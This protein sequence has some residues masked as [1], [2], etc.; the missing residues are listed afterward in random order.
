M[1]FIGE[2]VDKSDERGYTCAAG[3]KRHIV[4]IAD[5]EIPIGQLHPD[6]PA[7]LKFILHTGGVASPDGIGDPQIIPLARGTGDGEDTGFGPE[8]AGI[9][10]IE[11]QVKELAGFKAG[12]G[13]LGSKIDGIDMIAVIGDFTYQAT[14]F[15]RGGHLRYTL[16]GHKA[17][18]HGPDM[19]QSLV[20]DSGINADE[21]SVAHDE[22]CVRQVPRNAMGDV[23]I[24]GVTQEIAAEEVSGFDAVGFQKCGQVVAGKIGLIFHSDDIAEPGGIGI[25]RGPGK[26]ETVFEGFQDLGEFPEILLTPGDELVK[27]PE[28]GATDGGLHVRDLEVVADM[29]VNVFVIITKG[30]GAELLAEAFPA[31]VAFPPG[32]VTI[33]APVADGAG[34][35]GQI[36]VIRGHTAPF[37]QG[38]VMGRVEGKG[39]EVAEGAG[40]TSAEC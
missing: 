25:L 2:A 8:T 15:L 28:L 9:V 19:I 10:V 38:D 6:H 17:I 5:H 35:A 7:F 20:I 32:A 30:Q 31:G 37:A 4:C 33:P 39:G 26:D 22:I 27:F 16:P 1:E 14:E 18:E 13:P 34:D 12:H 40:K 36:V 29:A 24:C 11:R 21:E 3:Q 23:L